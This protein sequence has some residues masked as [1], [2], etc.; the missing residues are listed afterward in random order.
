M[1]SLTAAAGEFIEAE[2]YQIPRND[3]ARLL[4]GTLQS[5]GLQRTA[6]TLCRE[7]N[8]AGEP[9]VVETTRRHIVSGYNAPSH[10]LNNSTQLENRSEMGNGKMC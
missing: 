6:E 10:C 3:L 2:G 9:E 5:M 7:A 1:E 4:A 8:V